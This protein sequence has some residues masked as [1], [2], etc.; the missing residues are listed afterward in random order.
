MRPQVPEFEPHFRVIQ[1]S[2]EGMRPAKDRSCHWATIVGADELLPKPGKDAS[3][4][5]LRMDIR[6]VSLRWCW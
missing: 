2:G 6:N 1:L 3:T 5:L 4:R